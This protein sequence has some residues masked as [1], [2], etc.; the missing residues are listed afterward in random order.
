[1]VLLDL[2]SRRKRNANKVGDDVYQYDTMSEKLRN[3]VLFVVDRWDDGFRAY[4]TVTYPIYNT[5]VNALRTELGIKKLSR[6]YNCEDNE[7]FHEWFLAHSEVDELLDAIELCVRVGRFCHKKLN[8]YDRVEN[9][10]AEINARMLEAGFGYQIEDVNIYQLNS[11]FIH[12]QITVPSLEL[13]SGDE[14][15]TANDEFRQAY[16]EFNNGN[17]DDCI[18]DC[19]N[20]FESVLKIIL[21]AK[22]WAFS[23]NDPAKKL[24]AVAFDQELIPAYMQAEFTGLRTILE[25]GVPTV[26]NKDGGHGAGATPR[27]IPKHIAAFQLHQTAA[28]IVLLV[29]AAK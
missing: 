18:H 10:I 27:K 13:L 3:Q 19:C 20:A 11:T 15:I 6:S 21:T 9:D 29:E 17:Y 14:Y 22:G 7:E 23:A 12:K 2:Y 24:L 4:D 25:S 1:M 28:A 8:R 16:Q 26:R 5:V